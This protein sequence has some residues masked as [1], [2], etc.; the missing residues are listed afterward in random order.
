MIE[1]KDIT[2]ETKSQGYMEGDV[3]KYSRFDDLKID[4][5]LEKGEDVKNK[6]LTDQKLRKLIDERIKELPNESWS[7]EIT[8]GDPVSMTLT[9]K[10]FQKELE[11]LREAS[12]K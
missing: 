7:Q 10:G 3:P 12:E 8:E 1:D 11:R 2:I 5:H 9:K 6:I 4:C